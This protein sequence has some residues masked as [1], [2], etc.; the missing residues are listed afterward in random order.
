VNW[1]RRLFPVPE[2]EIPRFE[3]RFCAIYGIAPVGRVATLQ[4]EWRGMMRDSR[5]FLHTISAI[6]F[7]SLWKKL[8]TLVL[9]SLSLPPYSPLSEFTARYI[10]NPLARRR[11]AGR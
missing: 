1:T 2:A 9:S 6:S 5:H 3:A 8:G 7:W 10:A 4:N 11:V